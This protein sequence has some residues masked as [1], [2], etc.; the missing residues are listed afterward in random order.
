LIFTFDNNTNITIFFLEICPKGDDPL[1]QSAV[2]RVLTFTTTVGVWGRLESVKGSFIFSFNGQSFSFPPA[3]THFSG[4]QC[5]DAFNG[6]KNIRHANCTRSAID[7]KG[8]ATYTVF[9]QSFPRYP[10]ENNIFYN[11]GSSS[12]W[13]I[14]CRTDNIINKNDYL[15]SCSVSIRSDSPYSGNFL[16]T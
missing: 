4:Q 10:F 7:E 6:L 2:A 11:N 3:A 5:T 9:L 15:P 8:G 16:Y 13:N 14:V 12:S 1:T